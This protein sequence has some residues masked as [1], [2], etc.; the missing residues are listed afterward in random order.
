M[1]TQIAPFSKAPRTL[2]DIAAQ[3]RKGYQD[4]AALGQAN[5]EA[6]VKSTTIL[7]KGTED[8][9]RQVA[10]YTQASFEKAVATSQ[11][12]LTVK[13]P[14]DLFALQSAFAQQSVPSLIAESARLSH[15]STRIVEEAFAP[16]ATR[17]E[18]TAA[19]VSK[20]LAA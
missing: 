12:L 11:N 14:R 8:L 6:V 1:T 7:V 9:G 18:V 3:T 10:A 16:I 17:L 5:A 19:T 20:P 2:N 13:S 4:L 15:Q